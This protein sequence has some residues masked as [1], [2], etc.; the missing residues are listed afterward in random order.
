MNDFFNK[1]KEVQKKFKNIDIYGSFNKYVEEVLSNA[2]PIEIVDF[3][4]GMLD[5]T[6]NE[7]MFLYAR[8]IAEKQ[9]SEYI[10][11]TII[12]SF[13]NI[14]KGKSK[15]HWA[16]EFVSSLLN[17]SNLKLFNYQASLIV[18]M[19]LTY[20]GEY[21]T[22]FFDIMKNK[23]WFTELK[24]YL[25]DAVLSNLN[26]ITPD[27]MKGVLHAVMDHYFYKR[28]L[29][30]TEDPNMFAGIISEY[31]HNE[32]QIE[33]FIGGVDITF[34]LKDYETKFINNEQAMMYISTLISKFYTIETGKLF[35]D[36]L[37]KGSW[38]DTRKIMWLKKM[39]KIG[40][41]EVNTKLLELTKDM[42]YA[43][44][45]VRDIFMF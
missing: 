23:T 5:K 38:T 45:E 42:K 22:W 9:N 28:I 27:N 8:T 16:Y 7:V 2:H 32:K 40:S 14:V 44:Q 4:K 33:G 34:M 12:S 1:G 29:E 24:P 10:W 11:E 13:N 3:I 6:K 15:P 31:R 37:Y 21:S 43:P 39:D 25:L 36:I 17:Y 19:I 26:K 41:V 20:N 30:K 18:T 35:V